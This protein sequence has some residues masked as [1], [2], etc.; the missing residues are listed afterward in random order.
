MSDLSQFSDLAK[1]RAIV[2]LPTPRVPVNRKAWWMRPLVERMRQ[3][4][5]HMLLADQFSETLR[6]PFAR[7]DLIGHHGIRR[8]T[9]RLCQ[10][11]PRAGQLN[12]S[13]TL[14]CMKQA[15]ILRAPSPRASE[16]C[17]SGFHAERCPSG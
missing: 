5:H 14:V 9:C 10:P 4:A 16:S 1:M 13:P 17:A 3:R 6:A 11:R 15:S 8:G 12:L 7:E 2:V